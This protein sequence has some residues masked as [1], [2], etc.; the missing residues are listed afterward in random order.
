MTTPHFKLDFSLPIPSLRSGGNLRISLPIQDFVPVE[1]ALQRFFCW[2]QVKSLRK[3]DYQI[4]GVHWL[5][6]KELSPLP[7]RWANRR[8][9]LLA[10][11][12]G[13]GKTIQVLG[14][15]MVNPLPRT[16]IVLPL[17]LLEQWRGIIQKITGIAP[18]VYHGPKRFQIS[19]SKMR[20]QRIILTTYGHIA[21]NEDDPPSALHTIRFDR[22]IFDEAHHLR[23]ERTKKH[24]GARA[25][26]SATTWLL[27]G[28][29]IQN[30][31]ADYYNLLRILG[32][33]RTIAKENLPEIS[34]QFMLRRTKAEVSL[35]LKEVEE[36]KCMVPW[37]CP[38]EKMLAEDI[39]RLF[40]FSRTAEFGSRPAH[41]QT[42]E[43]RK[44]VL[45]ALLRA[46]QACILPPLMHKVVSQL[47]DNN[48][49]T[50]YNLA[51]GLAST[52]KVRAVCDK[53]IERSRN[54]RKKLIFT[55][56]REEIN[57][58]ARILRDNALSVGVYDGRANSKDRKRLIENQELD[59]LLIQI[60]SGSEG[61]NLQHFKEVY[62]VSPGWNPAV[63]DQAI[64]RCHRMGQTDTVSIF[65]FE[66]EPLSGGGQTLDR[67]CGR[68]QEQKRDLAKQLV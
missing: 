59:V 47:P 2:L 31:L 25:L 34:Q 43:L 58:I 24:I 27:T 66:M 6:Q 12:M 64:A 49:D 35:D 36:T 19:S 63:E 1:C 3:E 68:T 14:A 53:V 55:H 28:T 46:R 57:T 9:G 40:H 67:Y 60:M 37:G 56:F 21:L 4:K 5:L 50:D 8:G 30:G 41:S 10:D 17:A 65:R 26:K 23:N 7:A 48:A 52:S 32:F 51:S 62:F 42:P 20:S 29:P 38:E 54:G 15:M 39:H 18:L 61:L 44:N 45:T 16:L 22:L 33:T 11:E 13:L